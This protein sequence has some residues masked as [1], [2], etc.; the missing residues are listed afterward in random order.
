MGG[1]NKIAKEIIDQLPPADNFVD[2]FAGGCAVA[3]AAMM[4][5]KY[6]NIIINDITNTPQ[7][8]LDAVNGKYR[9][10]SRWISREYCLS[11]LDDAYIRCCWTFSNNGKTY[12]YGRK[13]EQYKESLWECIMHDDFKL[14]YERMP[15]VADDVYNAIHNINNIKERRL[16]LQHTIEKYIKSSNHS[17]EEVKQILS[18]PLYRTITKS[19]TSASHHPLMQSLERLQSLQSLQSLERLESLQSLEMLKKPNINIYQLDYRDVVIPDNSII[20]CDIPYFGT[21]NYSSD[22][23]HKSFYQWALNQ[24]H[25]YI[26]EYTMPED[27]FKCIWHKEVVRKGSATKAQKCRESVW[28]PIK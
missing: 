15:E 6:K 4:S 27:K 3:G 24:M 12:M 28:V 1:K 18:H 26:S 7:L 5:G 8:W 22:F 17:E 21:Q 20:Y 25:I 9:D 23:D 16:T 11:H 14:I 19:K 10:E 2:L 13:V